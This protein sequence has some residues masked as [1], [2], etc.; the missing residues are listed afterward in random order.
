MAA[1]LRYRG[2]GFGAQF[3]RVLSKIGDLE[4][5]KVGRSFDLVQKRRRHIGH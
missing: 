3:V 5:A 2:D 4:T 1:S